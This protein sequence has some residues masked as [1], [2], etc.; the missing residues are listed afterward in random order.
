M[1]VAIFTL[2][3]RGLITTAYNMVIVLIVFAWFWH[4]PDWRVILIVPGLALTMCFFVPIC[5]VL[6][7]IATRFRDAV[8]LTQ[9]ITQ[10][11]YFI[12]PVLWRPEFIPEP[13][14]WINSVNPFSVY[15]S[16]LRDPLLAMET[17]PMTW[18]VAIGY[19]VGAWL[20][21]I[22]FIGAYHK[23]VIYWI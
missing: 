17:S 19:V 5:Y 13:Y 3:Y 10:I 23:R 14:R 15:L 1:A 16:L 20:F 8:P 12:T 4:W 18:L 9:S 22:P 6:A 2:V 21:A 11:G 7:I